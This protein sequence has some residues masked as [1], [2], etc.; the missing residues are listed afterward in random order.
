MC[1]YEGVLVVDKPSGCT[2]HDVIRRLR[3]ILGEKRIGHAGTLDPMATG[4]LPVFVGRATKQIQY[5]PGHKRYLAEL[6]LGLTTDT[7]DCTG[8]VLAT[9]EHRPH[10]DEMLRALDG[11]RG[12]I[13]QI[14]PMVSAVQIGGQR[15][16][17]LHRKGLEVERAPRPL[18]VSELTLEPLDL[19][20]FT[21]TVSVS[22][23]GYIRTLIHDLGQVWG[24][25]AVMT[26]LRRVQAGPYTEAMALSL[27]QI[28]EYHGKGELQ[29]RK[30]ESA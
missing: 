3:G 7:Q 17:K 10:W 11:F 8:R 29:C 15:L 2:S 16:Y 18:H 25:G 26:A 4:V 28:A 6:A 27:R 30:P 19:D 22:K 14:P 23:G 13:L 24:C 5:M 20:E 12:D 1:S 21:L 9:S